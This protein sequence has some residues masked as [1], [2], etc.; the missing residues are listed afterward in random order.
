MTQK[1]SRSV[2]V[3]Q[4]KGIH[5]MTSQCLGGASRS[6][7]SLG[8]LNSYEEEEDEVMRIAYGIHPS[9]QNG[10]SPKFTHP[11]GWKSD[12]VEDKPWGP[13]SS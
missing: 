3:C 9:Q 6:V 7:T 12:G 2:L 10:V 8:L 4:K 1:N 13:S 11:E 5:T